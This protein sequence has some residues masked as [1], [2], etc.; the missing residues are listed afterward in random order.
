MS[1]RAG[2]RRTRA[3]RIL[4]LFANEEM[5]EQNPEGQGDLY[6]PVVPLRR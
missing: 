3:N 2:L 1:D 4:G 6:E 5:L